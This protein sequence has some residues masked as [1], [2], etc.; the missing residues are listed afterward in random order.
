MEDCAQK[1]I[2]VSDR[3]IPQ[4]ETRLQSNVNNTLLNNINMKLNVSIGWFHRFIKQHG[5]RQIVIHGEASSAPDVAGALPGILKR[6]DILRQMIHSMLMI[7]AYSVGLP[8][9]AL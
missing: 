9:I 3:F 8:L 5:F 2:S 1:T 7:L 4:K 6:L